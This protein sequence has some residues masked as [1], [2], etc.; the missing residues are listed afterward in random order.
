MINVANNKQM[1]NGNYHQLNRHTIH[2][3]IYTRD[4]KCCGSDKQLV[5]DNIHFV[6]PNG[7][8][9]NEVFVLGFSC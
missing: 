1:I 5:A 9:A 6:E 8:F 3:K 7:S 4:E 2:L